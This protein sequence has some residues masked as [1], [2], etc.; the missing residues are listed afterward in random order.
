[1]ARRP[2]IGLMIIDYL[3]TNEELVGYEFIK[4]CKEI[5]MHASPGN[6]YPH[7]CHMK[8]KGIVDCKIDG[9]RKVY[10]LT[11]KGKKEIMFLKGLDNNSSRFFM[12]EFFKFAFKIKQANFSSKEEVNVLI[13]DIEKM[14]KFLVSIIKEL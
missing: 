13:N 6:V 10:T 7:L 4:Y 3:M 9:K 14:K 8:K 2:F 11:E 12:K 5:G 1:M